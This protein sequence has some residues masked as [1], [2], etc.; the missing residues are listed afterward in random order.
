MVYKE[1]M[2]RVVAEMLR[3]QWEQNYIANR[4]RIRTTMP[5]HL[6]KDAGKAALC[7]GAGPSLRKNIEF[8]DDGYYDIIA[9]D[10]ICGMLVDHGNMPKYVVALNAAHT[11]VQKWLEPVNEPEVTLVVPCGVN[12]EA[13]DK[14][15]GQLVFI[16]AVTATG[17]ENRVYSETGHYPLMVG[18]N[19]GTFAYLM[20]N[21]LGY[22]P[23]GYCGM[24]FSYLTRKEVEDQISGSGEPWNIVEMTGYGGDVRYT[25]LGWVYMAD[26]FQEHAKR[27]AMEDINTV[28]CGEGGINFS[29]YTMPMTLKD[30]NEMVK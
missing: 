28:F 21:Y 1:Q 27:M 3:D 20:A 26:A 14:W 7:V 10:K 17:M 18:S 9:C 8:I 22:N 29:G 24:D 16:N 5:L 23:I 19:A 15:S 25:T 13:W 11:D 30:F 4:V 12:P 2:S 6:V